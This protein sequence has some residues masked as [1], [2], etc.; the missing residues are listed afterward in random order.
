M[1]F[2]HSLAIIGKLNEPLFLYSTPRNEN[3]ESDYLHMQYLLHNA[4]DVIE[5]R[6]GKRSPT[7]IL[8]MYLGQLYPVEDYRI[9]GYYSNTLTKIVA[10][11]DSTTSEPDLRENPFQSLG[12]P[13]TSPRIKTKV[14]LLI[15][16]INESKS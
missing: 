2:V 16:S 7:S 12:K 10:V 3:I 11:C 13:I 1:V 4:L 14:V 5:E 9:F 15:T 6:R 8:D